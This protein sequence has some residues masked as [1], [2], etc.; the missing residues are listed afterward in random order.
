MGRVAEAAQDAALFEQGPDGRDEVIA[1]VAERLSILGHDQESTELA[2][3]AARLR[4]LID[5][6]KCRWC[7]IVIPFGKH[8]TALGATF[9]SR[10]HM[11]EA[12]LVP[13]PT[14]DA[15]CPPPPNV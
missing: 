10:Q 5:P 15:P 14:E 11:D 9:C 7:G 2:H 8:Y 1:E 6:P 12:L 13:D 4:S 3:L